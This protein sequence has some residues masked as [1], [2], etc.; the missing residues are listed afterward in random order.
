LDPMMVVVVVRVV[1]ENH[2]HFTVSLLLPISWAP[3]DLSMRTDH[4]LCPAG[5]ENQEISD[6]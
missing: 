4:R 3:F 6:G 1:R 5:L 2:E